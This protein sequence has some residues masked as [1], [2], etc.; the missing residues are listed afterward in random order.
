[1]LTCNACTRRGIR[2]QGQHGPH[3]AITGYPLRLHRRRGTPRSHLHR[4]RISSNRTEERGTGT[5]S[6]LRGSGRTAS[7]AL[8][9]LD[10]QSSAIGGDHHKS[11]IAH[12]F[13]TSSS[14]ASAASS[15]GGKTSRRKPAAP[16][17]PASSYI[18]PGPWDFLVWEFFAPLVPSYP[19]SFGME[20]ERSHRR[21]S[22]RTLAAAD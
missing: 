22:N 17:S 19:H 15:H 4:L 14:G 13:C 6:C 8:Q 11:T 20:R 16:E 18:R 12:C 2:S 9:R 1:M 21:A 3:L 5:I 10:R 7:P